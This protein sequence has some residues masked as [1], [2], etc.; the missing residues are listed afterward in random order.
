MPFRRIDSDEPAVYAL[1]RV[2]VGKY[3]LLERF[4]YIDSIT[5]G[6]QFVVPRDPDDFVTDLASVPFFATWL[7]PRDG[8]HTPAALLHDALIQ[9][10]YDGGKVTD[11]QADRVFRN[12]MGE[13]G[14]PLLR[15]W[16]MWAAVS[17]A[18]M[19]RGRWPQRLWLVVTV[20]VTLTAILLTELYAAGDAVYGDQSWRSEW[21][22]E[23]LLGVELQ[24]FILVG[25]I[26][27]GPRLDVSL[28]ATAALIAFAIP[29][30]AAALWFAL[31]F[32]VEVLVFLAFWLWR[33][34]PAPNAPVTIAPP[35]P[36]PR[37][38]EFQ[39]TVMPNS[40]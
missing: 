31:Y 18:T 2:G 16:M 10:N 21:M 33:V 34:S 3:K 23:S 1:R 39:A 37:A 8:T 32:V 6:T 30:L 11:P 7:V 17:L 14:V 13:L 25:L 9:R 4:R 26:L 28:V 20:L 29:L 15:R 24:W 19:W 22:P 36:L 40:K 35:Q 27:A 5:M 12:V 38:I